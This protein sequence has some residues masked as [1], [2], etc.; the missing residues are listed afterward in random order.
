MVSS[1]ALAEKMALKLDKS[2]FSE[3]YN[4]VVKFAGLSDKRYPV[5]GMNVWTPYGW[6]VMR[7]IDENIRQELDETGHG[8]VCFPLLIPNTEF[9]KEA[10]HIEGFDSQVFW[11]TR[12]GLNELDVPLLLRPTSETA[13]YPMFSLWVRSH[14]DLPLK[15]YQLVNTFRYETKQTRSFIRVREIHFF[16]AHTC[17]EDLEDAERQIVEDLEIMARLGE[18][19]CIPY[20]TRKRPDWDKFA[21]AFYTFGIDCVMPNAKTLQLGSIHQYKTN[22]SKPYDIKFEDAKGEHKYVYQTTYGMSERL[23]GAIVGI[24]GDNK[25]LVLPPDVAPMQIVI[26]PI[27]TRKRK[28]DV[29]ICAREIKESLRKAG[30]RVHLDDTDVRPG[31]KFYQWELKGV[32]LRLEIGPRDVDAGKVVLVRRTDGDKAFVEMGELEKGVELALDV[33]KGQMMERAR[34]IVDSLTLDVTYADEVH[35]GEPGLVNIGWCG[36]ESC[37]TEMEITLDMSMLGID[38]TQ[39]NP[40]GKCGQCGSPAKHYVTYAKTY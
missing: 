8:E 25:G 35:G 33:I 21:G 40:S 7:L 13:M 31:N 20:L 17:H 3:W 24:H 12:A 26:V 16:E 5:K 29:L 9:Q 19:L 6:K 27:L 36:L 22:F 32:P 11:V 37:S 4:D 38:T 34:K 14:S 23:V 28:D 10:E 2:N 39:K 1:E 30:Y 18:K 15:T